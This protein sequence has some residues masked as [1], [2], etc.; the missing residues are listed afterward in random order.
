MNLPNLLV[1]RE[2]MNESTRPYDGDELGH[3]GGGVDC[4]S[5]EQ[6]QREAAHPGGGPPLPHLPA[7]PRRLHSFSLPL[8]RPPGLPLRRR[9]VAADASKLMA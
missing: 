1:V 3:Q 4:R 5:G 7:P 8:P 2:C 6:P 9:G